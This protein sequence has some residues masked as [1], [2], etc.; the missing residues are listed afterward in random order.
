M[1]ETDVGYGPEIIL[2]A[3]AGGFAAQSATGAPVLPAGCWGL[4]VVAA[5]GGLR[6][7][8]RAGP[9]AWNCAVPARVRAV[10]PGAAQY[11]GP[12]GGESRDAQELVVRAEALA[13]DRRPVAEE[14]SGRA[15]R[16]GR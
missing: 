10:R 8:V 5:G 9:A 16:R 11:P 2:V 14:M 1:A 13:G 7:W 6:D 4:L 15:R 3:A 12:A